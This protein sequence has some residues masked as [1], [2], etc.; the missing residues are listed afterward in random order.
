M[1]KRV[2]RIALL[3]AAFISLM[4]NCHHEPAPDAIDTAVPP[5]GAVTLESSQ[6][7]E[8]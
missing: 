4:V 2:F 5:P 6:A 1:S 7:V 3:I 8:N